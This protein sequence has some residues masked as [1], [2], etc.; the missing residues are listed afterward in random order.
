[1]SEDEGLG[2]VSEGEGLRVVSED[3]GSVLRVMGMVRGMMRMMRMGVRGV[4][5]VRT[6]MG[7]CVSV[8]VMLYHNL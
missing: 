3:D 2:V 8:C 4:V 5:G 6:R 1:M 7:V